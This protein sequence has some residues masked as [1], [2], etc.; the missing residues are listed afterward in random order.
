MHEGE[1]EEELLGWCG[2]TKQRSIRDGRP[3]ESAKILT[4]MNMFRL[5]LPAA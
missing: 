4:T 3:C 2:T 5:I 1:E